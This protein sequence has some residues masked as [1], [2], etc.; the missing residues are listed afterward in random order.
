MNETIAMITI[1]AMVIAAAAAI[2]AIDTRT[3]Q[4][5]Y[6]CYVSVESDRLTHRTERVL[7]CDPD[8][9][10]RVEWRHWER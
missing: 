9:Y 2:L 8:S 3:D 4:L 7:V 10:D 1:T 6:P 5:R